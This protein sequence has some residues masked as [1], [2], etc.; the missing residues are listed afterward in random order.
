[1]TIATLFDVLR[2]AAATG[3]AVAGLVVLGW[4]DASAYVQAA[5]EAGVPVILQAGPGCRAHMPVKV[6]GAM[7]RHLAEQANVPVV[8]HVDH[9]RSFEECVAGIDAGFTSVMID[10]SALPLQA[11]IDLTGKA[12]EAARRAGVSVEGEIG[13]VG[14][15]GGTKSAF[16]RPEDAAAFEEATGVDAL[17]VSV[18]NVHLSTEKTDGI[19]FVAISAI[20]E[21]TK[22]PLVLH[23]GSGIPEAVRKR[24]ACDYRVAKFN[25]GTELRIAFGAELRNQLAS[26]PERF[27]RNEILKSVMPLL[28]AK[29]V[30]L[31]KSL[32]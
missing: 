30:Q 27:D 31:L 25:I 24:L 4:E 26:H 17:A 9:A 20:A 21:K 3:K 1:V 14:Y 10:G 5:D 18:G 11:N 28:R 22:V 6:L 19:D 29:T 12:V 16:T 8:C 15:V 13:Y 32:S 2:P 7:F 23:G